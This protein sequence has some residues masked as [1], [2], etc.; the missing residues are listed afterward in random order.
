MQPLTVVPD[1]D[2]FEDCP[3]GLGAGGEVG[4]VDELGLERLEEALGDGVVPA[5]TLAAHAADHAV[6]VEDSAV[7]MACRRTSETAAI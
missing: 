3:A 2:E 1:F 6:G 5:V 4:A 7:V